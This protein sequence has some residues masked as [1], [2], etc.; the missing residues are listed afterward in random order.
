MK[1][2]LEYE[3]KNKIITHFEEIAHLKNEKAIELNQI[4]DKIEFSMKEMVGIHKDQEITQQDLK[5][6]FTDFIKNT[7]AEQLIEKQKAWLK[8]KEQFDEFDKLEIQAYKEQ[9]EK[10]YQILSEILD[11]LH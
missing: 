6:R 11:M 8:L 10:S 3:L 9:A 7:P 5:E 1:E 4:A 2:S